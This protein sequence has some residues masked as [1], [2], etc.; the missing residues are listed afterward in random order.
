MV[1]NDDFYSFLTILQVCTSGVPG[2]TWEVPERPGVKMP[3]FGAFRTLAHMGPQG[4]LGGPRV[5]RGV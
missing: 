3:H 5:P 4:Y 1:K 2:G